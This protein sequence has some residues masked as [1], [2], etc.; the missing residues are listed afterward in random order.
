MKGESDDN[1]ITEA[2]DFVIVRKNRK[3]KLGVEK[4]KKGENKESAEKENEKEAK[5]S[6]DSKS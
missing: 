6:C 1:N 4:Q 3:F 5:G 2:W